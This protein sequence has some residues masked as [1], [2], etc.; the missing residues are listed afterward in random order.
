MFALS[1]SKRTAEAAVAGLEVSYDD[2]EEQRQPVGHG[3]KEGELCVVQSDGK[4]VT[5]HACE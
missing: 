1:M 5:M 2:Y 3:V 4:G